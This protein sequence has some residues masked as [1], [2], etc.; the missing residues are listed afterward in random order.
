TETREQAVASGKGFID[1]LNGQQAPKAAVDASIDEILA[2][3]DELAVNRYDSEWGGFAQQP[4]YAPKFPR[5][6]ETILLLRRGRRTEQP[7]LEEM[8][9]ETLDSMVSGGMYDQVGGGFA[10]YSVDRAWLVPHFEKMLYDNALLVE[11]YLEGWQATRNTKYERIARETLD[12]L[13]KE[14]RSPE[15]GFYSATDAD[16]LAPDGELVEGYFFVWTMKEFDEVTG[17]D[18]EIAKA[19]FGVKEEG[20]FDEVPGG[21]VLS[22]RHTAAKVAKDLGVSALDVR[23]AVASAKRKLYEA[24]AKRT[25]PR[26][27]DKV[28]SSWNGL[29]LTA[30]SRAAGI[31]GDERYLEVARQNADFLLTKM[32]AED[33]GL[34]RT[35]R[36]GVSTLTGFLQDHAFVVQGLIDLF[37]ADQNPETKARWLKAAMD[38]HAQTEKE[39]AAE[40]GGYLTVAKSRAN[41]LPIELRTAQEGSL[42]SDVITAASNAYR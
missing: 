31:L 10:R 39:F 8:A 40:D 30:F 42:P 2:K 38:L 36:L 28:L 18:A 34:Y 4:N 9:L 37:E 32:R 1:G 11:V 26:L 22:A 21:N 14:M 12:Y 25:P 27:D 17:E 35:R 6:T 24:R 29:A 33:G 23:L 16:S 7:N 5:A 19:W 41:K 3:F 20:N 15:G 13:I